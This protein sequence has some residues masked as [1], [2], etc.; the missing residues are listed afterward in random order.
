MRKFSRY[1]KILLAIFVLTLPLVNPWV[2]GD[3]VGYYAFARSLL[4]QRNLDFTKD[5]EEANSS[6]RL[7]RTDE[8]GNVLPDQYTPTGHIDNHFSIGPAILWSP[9]LLIAHASVIAANALG[10][11][12]SIDG[13]SLPYRLAMAIGTAF[14]GFLSLWI[15]FQLARKYFSDRSAFLATVG[16]WFAS[17]LP[18]YMYFNPSWS[19]A[20][21]AF[22]VALFVWYWDRTRNGRTLTQWAILG[23]ISGLMLNVYYL[24]GLLLLIP[25]L[26]SLIKYASALDAKDFGRARQLLIANIIFLLATVVASLPSLISK[27]I[28]YGGFFDTG[29]TEKWYWS[30]PAFLKV[31]FSPDHGL[32]SWTPIILFSFAGLFLFRKKDSQLATFLLIVFAVHVYVVGCLQYWDGTSSFGSRYCLPLMVMFVLGLA[33]FLEWIVRFSSSRR[34]TIATWAVLGL[35]IAWNLGL[36]FQWG[37][38]LIPARGPISWREAAYNQVAVVPVNAVRTIE[39]YFSQRSQMMR[40][41]EQEDM[42]LLVGGQSK[43]KD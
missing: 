3:G 37:T 18:V 12:I 22:C 11:H 20:H 35:L 34:A 14:Y 29:Y 15:S 26:E 43:S 24:C 25:L 16:I 8:Q 13:F 23:A 33:A 9:F 39:N 41:I 4:V 38:H 30:S 19:H 32:F 6:F 27:R 36:I 28:I 2:R 17:S 31:I 21:S 40:R 42:K 1:E 10:K 5:W 7:L